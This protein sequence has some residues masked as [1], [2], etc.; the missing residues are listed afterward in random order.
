M[1]ERHLQHKQPLRRGR[2]PKCRK[3]QRN[4]FL[5]VHEINNF[6]A[7]N[8]ITREAV[9]VPRKYSHAIHFLNLGNHGGKHFSSGFLC[10]FR[11]GK[12]LENFH[13]FSTR[14]FA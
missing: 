13:I 6:S 1:T 14:I 2:K 8:R 3:A 4:D 10:A 12:F 7:I 9:G 11:L 5:R